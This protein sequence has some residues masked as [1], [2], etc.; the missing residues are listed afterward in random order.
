MEEDEDIHEV[1]VVEESPKKS[2][3]SEVRSVLTSYSLYMLMSDLT[4]ISIPC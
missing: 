1:E 3:A 4:H 2:T